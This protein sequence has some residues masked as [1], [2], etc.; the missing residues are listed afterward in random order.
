M[1]T[2]SKKGFKR[3]EEFFVKEGRRPNPKAEGEKTLGLQLQCMD[4]CYKNNQ[5]MMKNPELKELWTQL[6][7]KVPAALW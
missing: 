5:Y 3:I 2:I 1:K 6:R 7:V 4:R